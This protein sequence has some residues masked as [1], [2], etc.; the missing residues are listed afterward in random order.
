MDT[1]LIV[2]LISAI[3]ACSTRRRHVIIGIS[4]AVG[5]QTA[6]LLRSVKGIETAS[7]AMSLL[8][9]CF[10]GYVIALVLGSVFRDSHR[11]SMDTIC[12]GLSAYLLLGIAWAF[13]YALLES[14]APGSFSGIDSGEGFTDYKRFLGY[15]FVTL[16]TLGY[17]NMYPLTP[18]ADSVAVTE[19]IVGQI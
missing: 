16:T 11:V 5:V 19:A 2:T 13:A 3:V 4:L 1:L 15:S 17:G 14:T 9:L 6:V 7:I 10:F 8:A 12:G 18:Q